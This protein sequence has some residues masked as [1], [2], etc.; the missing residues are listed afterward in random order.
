[1]KKLFLPFLLICAFCIGKFS[2][3]EMLTLPSANEGG[4][5]FFNV[6]NV[7]GFL[8][9]CEKN[10]IDSFEVDFAEK[11]LYYESTLGPNWWRYFFEPIH[12]E[13]F[14]SKISRFL[15][16]SKL[17]RISQHQIAFFNYDGEYYLSRTK[18]FKLISKYIRIKPEIA[19]EIEL[20]KKKHF[21]GVFVIGVHYRGTDKYTEAPEVDYKQVK[22][23]IHAVITEQDNTPYKIFVA[24]DSQKFL[25]YMYLTFPD[26]IITTDAMRSTDENPLHYGIKHE[27]VLYHYI[28]GKETIIDALLLSHTNTL[29]R[30]SSNLSLC[31]SFFNPE[32]PVILLNK[33]HPMERKV[34]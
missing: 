18:A 27:K 21:D 26:A 25:D 11:G 9:Y 20:F 13:S 33:K 29:I 16:L 15:R 14:R 31:S 12:K 30:T 6:V 28:Q 10:H 24:T 1:M 19:Q 23:T 5:I 17:C 34:N 7:L 4:G 32:I 22:A 3:S 2:T 8:R